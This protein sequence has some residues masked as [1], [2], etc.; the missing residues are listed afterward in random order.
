MILSVALLSATGLMAQSFNVDTEGASVEFTW[1]DDG[2]TGTLTGVNAQLNLDY[3][4]LGSATVT[5]SVNVNTMD[6]GIKGRDKHLMSE[7]YFH[8]DEFPTMDFTSS[9]LSQDGDDYKATGT[10]TVKG[11]EKEVTFIITSVRGELHFSTSIYANDFCVTHNKDKESSK[12]DIT[13][14]IPTTE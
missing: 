7:D 9:S 14:K 3:A 12:V 2:T 4:N 5:G 8:V 10:L 6:T 13:V 11:V 1:V